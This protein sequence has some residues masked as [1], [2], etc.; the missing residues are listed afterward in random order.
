MLS[1]NTALHNACSQGDLP[2]A[3]LLLHAG[4]DTQ[5]T[6][7]KGKTPEEKLPEENKQAFRNLKEAKSKCMFCLCIFQGFMSK[8]V[9]DLAVDLFRCKA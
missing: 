1:G 6:N 3:E 8:T 4:A 9:G 7:Q 5:I 2:V